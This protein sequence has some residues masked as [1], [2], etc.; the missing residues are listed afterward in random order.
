MTTHSNRWM[1]LW[2]A[3]LAVSCSDSTDDNGGD[4]PGTGGSQSTGN[5]MSNGG[6]AGDSNASGSTGG[7]KSSNGSGGSHASKGTGGSSSSGS[8]GSHGGSGGSGVADAGNGTGGSRSVTDSGTPSYN[9]D[10]VQKWIDDYAKAH[11]GAS[12][13]INDKTPA[14]IAADPDAMRLLSLC[15][16]DQRPVIP[17][18]A[19]E[20]GGADHAWI[21][22]DMSALVYCVYIPVTPNTD[23]WSYDAGADH[24]TA[25][26]YVLYPDE[27]PC[28]DET[29]A[30]QVAK[31]IGDMT[32]FEIL[33]DTAS[34]NDGMDVGLQLSEAATELLLVRAGGS[35][36]HL[37]T[38]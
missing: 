27:N 30:D 34:L 38:D 7:S 24:V 28:K 1:V 29:A 37:W 17:T 14:E 31:C 22:P 18:L 15:G 16:E 21:N 25:D 23:H 2:I 8:G 36:V 12:G 35:K 20:H 3:A 19:W 10:G 13:D 11:P 33:V 9:Y 6:H 26:V 4:R 32:N 5:G